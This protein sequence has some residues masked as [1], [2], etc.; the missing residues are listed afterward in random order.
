M[1]ALLKKISWQ[2]I[3]IAALLVFGFATR[4][5]M[6]QSPSQVVFD[7]VHFGKFA[8]SYF[9]G[10][11]YFDIHPPL[12]KLLIAAGAALGGYGQYVK[13]HGVFDFATI[14]E[15]YAG[16]PYVGFR[17]FP[18]IAGA[19]LPLAIYLFVKSLKLSDL[20]ALGAGFLVLFDN[21]LLTQ[22][23][24][25]LMDSFLL[26]F[27]FLGLAVFFASRNREYDWKRLALAGFLFGLSMSVKWT[28]G[29][30][31]GLAGVVYVY[32][33][34]RY[35]LGHRDRA[36]LA[37]AHRFFIALGC[38]VILPL[39]VYYAVFAVH[40]HFLVHSG[41]GDAYMDQNFWKLPTLGK[42]IELNDKMWFYNTTLKAT[43]PYGSPAW[44]WPF[45]VRPIYYWIGTAL[46]GAAARIYLIGNPIAWM[47]GV[48][49]LVCGL[50]ID[51]MNEKQKFTYAVLFV[52][53]LSN[54][55]PF[56]DITRVLFLYHYFA[57][58]AFSFVLVSVWL[59]EAT[60]HVKPRLR[61]AV[62]A[63]LGIAVIAGF[64]FFAPLSYG[65]LL[66]DHAYH[67][68]TWMQSWI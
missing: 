34:V 9:D 64:L 58:L 4:L 12:G 37:L 40:F 67:L 22:S 61:I 18:A 5:W 60:E 13:E 27:G 63:L 2:K 30:F 3:G 33:A 21:A 15:Q 59:A 8:S 19:L 57:A 35:A 32:D 23:R 62:Y 25:A 43:H 51:K 55:L 16:M 45:M 48:V 11:Y 46:P 14:G 1:L 65:S 56:F 31:L 26:L 49:G 41:T 6:I 29:S 17:L 39:L 42:F 44:T 28:G 47:L 36:F 10:Q 54:F 53:Y 66:T 7:E 20:A 38:F 24:L 68:R 50:F 52:G